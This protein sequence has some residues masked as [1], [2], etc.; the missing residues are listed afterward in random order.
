MKI[1]GATVIACVRGHVRLALIGIGLLSL[2][3]GTLAAYQVTAIAE[4]FPF[5]S[6]NTPGDVSYSYTGPATSSAIVS[7]SSSP[8]AFVNVSGSVSNP[9]GT[10]QLNVGGVMTYS[11]AVAAAP[12]TTVPIDFSG[13]FSTYLGLS[14]LGQQGYA[15]F[16]LTATNP[17]AASYASFQSF[18]TGNCGAPSCYSIDTLNTNVALFQSDVQNLSG[19]FQGSLGMLTDVNG[20]VSGS[21]QISAGALVRVIA[22]TAV[23]T[24]YVDPSLHINAAYLATYPSTTLT[25]TPGVGNAIAAVPEPGTYALML[26]GIGM[27]GMLLTRRRHG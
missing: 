21:V 23:A 9:L 3:Q 7:F 20:M 16:N 22:G 5:G 15:T 10:T 19:S 13:V 17:T 14:G 26:V 8:I 6:S 25:L 11:F 24:S 27:M 1:F 18:F 2:A 4:S 12:F